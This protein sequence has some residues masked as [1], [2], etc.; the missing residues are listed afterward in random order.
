[1]TIDGGGWTTLT[2][3]KSKRFFGGSTKMVQLFGESKIYTENTKP[4]EPLVGSITAM[5]LFYG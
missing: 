1:M 3:R 2:L 4:F 5:A